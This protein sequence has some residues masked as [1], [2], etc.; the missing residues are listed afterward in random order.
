[1]PNICCSMKLYTCVFWNLDQ[2]V[3]EHGKGY[4]WNVLGNVAM[5]LVIKMSYIVHV[6]NL[7]D[8]A[9]AT[10]PK[11]NSLPLKSYRN[12]IGKDRLQVPPF[13]RFFCC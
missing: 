11:F 8:F 12:P 5:W 3:F 6:M 2:F 10:L 4:H 7:W 1:M 9:I 13:F